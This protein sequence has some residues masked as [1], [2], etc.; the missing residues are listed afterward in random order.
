MILEIGFERRKVFIFVHIKHFLCYFSG[1]EIGFPLPLSSSYSSWMT[2]EL[3]MLQTLHI[4][5]N[6][7]TITNDPK[8]VGSKRK[9]SYWIHGY[10]PQI[11]HFYF[12]KQTHGSWH[13][14]TLNIPFLDTRS[15]RVL[16]RTV[17]VFFSFSFFLFFTSSRFTKICANLQYLC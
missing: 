3:I 2:T 9:A 6:L 7:P 14:K 4:L 10:D 13:T 16:W 8:E 12:C 11:F 5:S 17:S 1:H 15:F